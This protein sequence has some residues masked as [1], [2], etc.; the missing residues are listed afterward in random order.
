M[1]KLKIL[2]GAVLIMLL[3]N[4]CAKKSPNGRMKTSEAPPAENE[5]ADASS[6]NNDPI[7]SLSAWSEPD[8]TSTEEK[9]IIPEFSEEEPVSELHWKKLVPGLEYT[10]APSFIRCTNIGDNLIR[11]V[12]ADMKKLKLR[13][14]CAGQLNIETLKAD[15]WCERY[16]MLAVINASMYGSD[17]FS[18]TGFMKNGNYFNNKRFN[19]AYKAIVVFDPPDDSLPYFQ[20]VDTGCRPDWKALVKRYRVAAQGLRMIDCNRANR[21]SRQKKY[22]STACIGE[23]GRGRVLFIHSR[24]PYMVSDLNRI[25]L[26]LPLNIRTVMYVEG[27]PESSLYV[28]AGGREIRSFGSYETG[29]NENDDNNDYWSIPNVIAIG[30]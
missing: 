2:A 16:G 10:E 5:F 12:R 23:D 29:F 11:I 8:T 6:E 28:R 3:L 20:I 7:K 18:S 1:F 26:S 30:Y 22:W 19:K 24:T 21:W 27:G 25:L 14:L 17:M 4:G 15:A 13:L 9:E